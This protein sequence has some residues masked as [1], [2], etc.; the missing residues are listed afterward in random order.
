MQAEGKG[1]KA[2]IDAFSH[3]SFLERIKLSSAG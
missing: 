3:S 2:S 1:G